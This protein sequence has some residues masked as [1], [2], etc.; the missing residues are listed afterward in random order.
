MAEVTHWVSLIKIAPEAA[1]DATAGP[2]AR[3]RGLD[4]AGRLPIRALTRMWQMLL[5]AL[6]EV[7]GA[8]NAMM[9]A[10]MA[11]IRLTHVA[12]LPSPEE[13]VRR[14]GSAPPTTP[15]ERA[16]V[17]VAAPRPTPAPRGGP[18]VARIAEPEPLPA[19]PGL[20][21]FDDLV[22]RI[23]DERDMTLLLAVEAHVRLVR[24][25]PGRIEFEPAGDAPPDLAPRLAR[26]LMDWTGTRWTVSLVS[27][28]GGATL[29]EAAHATRSTREAEA[30]RNPIVAAVLSAFPGSVIAEIREAVPA[31]VPVAEDWDPV[32]DG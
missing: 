26:R 14:L 25:S 8:P 22:A 11:V 12:D 5:K 23:R 31:A 30:L 27:A 28:G 15:A 9:A 17:A 29:R 13:I 16:P 2:D 24:M 20:A 10:E 21:T 3:A 1:D 18:A 6:E 7:A 19:P 32:E 4:L